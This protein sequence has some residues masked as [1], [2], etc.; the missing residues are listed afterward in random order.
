MVKGGVRFEGSC[1]LVVAT[2][3]GK[4]PGSCIIMSSG[5]NNINDLVLVAGHAPFLETTGAVPDHPESDAGWALQSFQRGEPPL[6]IEHVRQGV[7]LRAAN[8]EA[9]LVFS[10]GFT[11]REAGLRWSEA[12]T[13][14]AIAKHFGWWIPGVDRD[15]RSCMEART[16]VENFSR[17]SFENLLFSVCRFQQVVGRYPRKISVVS[18]AFKRERFDWHRETIR[19]PSARF[20]FAGCNEPI[21]LSSALQGEAVTLG[22]FTKN[23]Y[24]S[25]G[26][27]AEKRVARNPFHRQ[28]DFKN[29]PGLAGFFDFISDPANQW[30]DY[31]RPLPWEG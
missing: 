19:F 4:H 11:R 9:L 6:Y 30:R 10:G 27:L 7:A 13:Y 15:Q 2:G 5:W 3:K 12:D 18:W 16:A 24:G 23:R 22:D 29:C 28:H 20:H 26:R 1:S 31:P 8:P 17:D 14:L 25:D 21:G